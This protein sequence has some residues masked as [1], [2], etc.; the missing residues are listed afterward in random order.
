V[1]LDR[2]LSEALEAALGAEVVEAR[3]VAGGDINEAHAV[4]LADGREAFVKSNRGADPAMFEREASGLAWLAEA[5]ALRVPAVLAVGGE[6][7]RVPFLAL[8]LIR[9]GPRADDFDARLGHGLAMLHRSGADGFGLG[10]DNFIGNLPQ[11]NGPLP[12]WPDFYWA[13]R[14][15]PQLRAAF[16]AGSAPPGWHGRFARLQSRLPALVG[17]AEPPSRLHGDLWSGNVHVDEVGQPV[18]IDPAVYGGHREID[19]AMLA[20]FGSVGDDLIAAYEAV[21]PLADGWRDRVGLY[22]LYPLLV[23]V[24]LFGG[25]YVGAVEAALRSCL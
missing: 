24:N 8:E 2:G 12:S 17:P 3:P 19:L 15:E 4:R 20:L 16:D 25:S 10:E 1:S 9:S 11:E 21:A 6:E 23:H 14:L 13:R 7:A 22:Q 5:Q 18:L